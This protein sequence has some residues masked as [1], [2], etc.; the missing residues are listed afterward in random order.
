MWTSLK[1]SDGYVDMAC[2]KGKKGEDW[3]GRAFPVMQ[4]F[5]QPKRKLHLKHCYQQ[6]HD[7]GRDKSWL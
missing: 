3:A 6:G 7:L 2:V 5:S 4:T 1:V